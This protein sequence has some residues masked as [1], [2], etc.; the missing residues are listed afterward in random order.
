MQ[1]YGRLFSFF[2]ADD[3]I[4]VVIYC[5]LGVQ[6]IATPLINVAILANLYPRIKE[7]YSSKI[8]IKWACKLKVLFSVGL[9]VF[10]S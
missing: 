5:M 6:E 10:H 1:M 8:K 4:A 2:F 9:I 7:R 3:C